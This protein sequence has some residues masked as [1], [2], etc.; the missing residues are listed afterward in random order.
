MPILPVC[1]KHKSVAW[2]I[3]A[4]I[5]LEKRPIQTGKCLHWENHS[6]KTIRTIMQDAPLKKKINCYYNLSRSSNLNV[7]SMFM[8]Y[9]LQ[10]MQVYMP[11]PELIAKAGHLNISQT[12]AWLLKWP[13]ILNRIMVPL[14]EI[15]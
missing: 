14:L 6:I 1:R 2:Q 8:Q 11:I 13:F 7:S 9:G 4:A 5:L 12:A 3:S 10:K 15:D